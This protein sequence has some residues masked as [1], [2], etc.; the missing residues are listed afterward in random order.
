[1]REYARDLPTAEQVIERIEK[2][3][4]A[5][6]DFDY[7]TFSGNGEPTLHPD[8][9]LIAK[10]IRALKE[11]LRPNTRIA[12]LSNSTGLNS[13]KVLDVLSLIDCVYFKVDAGDEQTFRHINK[14]AQDV[15][16]NTIINTL[17]SLRNINIQTVLMTGTPSNVTQDALD[18]YFRVIEKIRP[19]GVQIYSLD[20]PVAH[21]SIIRVLPEELE[22]IA[23]T[24]FDRT[25]VPF[26]FFHL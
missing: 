4:H 13:R 19:Q 24:G 5:P 6:I 17:A 23:R 11:Q 3:M 21:G 9:A 20:R 14:P 10:K 8:F 18:S 22:G 7:I 2:V 1:M 26:Q 15:D 16:F 25:G 12:L